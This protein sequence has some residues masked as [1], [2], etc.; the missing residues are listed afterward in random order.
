MTYLLRCRLLAPLPIEK[1]FEAFEDPRNLARITPPWLS[2]RVTT[3]GDIAMRKG[4]EIEYTIRWLGLPMRW[5]TLI[6]GYD[7]P[8]S[9][10]DEQ[11]RGP[12]SLW[13][14]RHTFEAVAEGTIVTD[15]VE[16]RLPLGALGR[17]AHALVVGRQLKGIFAY[18]QRAMDGLLGVRCRPLE[19]PS[20]TVPLSGHRPADSANP[21]PRRP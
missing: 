14:H 7:P 21:E 15:S 19:E 11:A 8:R 12:Y 20:I 5:K 18:R 9:F 16:Y 13:R 6:T 4:A 3:G 17:I 10:V 2:F 1:T